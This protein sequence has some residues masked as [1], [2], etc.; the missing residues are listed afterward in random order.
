V[1]TIAESGL[2]GFEASAWDGIL[3]PAGTP[4][5]VVD[6]LNAAIQVALKD[7]AL[8][9]ALHKLGATPVPGTPEAFAQHIA[10][11]MVQWA[12]AVRAAGAKID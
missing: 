12:L 8:V 2:P 11:S 4:R 6:R 5:A 3:A 1:P 10:A 7:P 9:E